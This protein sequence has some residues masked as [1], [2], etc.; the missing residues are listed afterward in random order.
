MSAVDGGHQV[1]GR[2]TI[3]DAVHRDIAKPI[4]QGVG[5][6]TRRGVCPARRHRLTVPVR[7]IAITNQTSVSRLVRQSTM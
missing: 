3:T 2:K 1:A 5:G 4:G 7:M 6:Q